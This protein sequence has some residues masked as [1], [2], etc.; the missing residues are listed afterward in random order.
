M[1]LSSPGRSFG[2]PLQPPMRKAALLT[3][4]GLCFDEP[5]T[6]RSRSAR[7]STEPPQPEDQRPACRGCPTVPSAL[8]WGRGSKGRR[9]RVRGLKGRNL[10][11]G[12]PFGGDPV[13]TGTPPKLL[14]LLPLLD[15]HHDRRGRRDQGAGGTAGAPGGRELSVHLLLFANG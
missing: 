11:N 13:I 2:A 14:F 8:L 12:A 9:L 6:S 1:A 7:V 4:L 5:V 15:S 3:R 10:E